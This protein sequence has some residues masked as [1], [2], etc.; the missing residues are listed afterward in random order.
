[1]K[2]SIFIGLAVVAAGVLVLWILSAT[3]LFYP[4]GEIDFRG[5]DKQQVV[6]R[7]DLVR[8]PYDGH[9]NPMIHIT[10]KSTGKYYKTPEQALADRFVM[11][12]DEWLVNPKSRLWG[13]FY[14]KIKF[15]SNGIVVSQSVEV[16][17]DGP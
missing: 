6:Y 9:K 3:G 15:N 13:L 17:Q 1:M 4:G 14:Q 12:E 8:I 5:M 11:E 16:N 7:L 2:K 10:V